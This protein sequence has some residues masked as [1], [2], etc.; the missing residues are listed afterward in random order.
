MG[1]SQY[2]VRNQQMKRTW[3]MHGSSWAQRFAFDH[4]ASAVLMRIPEMQ[5]GFSEKRPCKWEKQACNLSLLICICEMLTIIW[6]LQTG[7][8]LLPRCFSRKQTR[9]REKL[10]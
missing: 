2:L 8:L 1:S 7:K 3:R 6:E 4:W 10:V 9:I 5:C